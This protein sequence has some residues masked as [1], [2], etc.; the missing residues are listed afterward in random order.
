MRITIIN[1]YDKRIDVCE[2]CESEG[3][4]TGKG[5]EILKKPRRTPQIKEKG[6]KASDRQ[7]P[8]IKQ[9]LQGKI[10]QIRKAKNTSIW[11][12]KKKSR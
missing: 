7:K 4:T 6:K 12:T 8:H 3:N 2:T 1:F 11:K 10:H 5:K 9:H